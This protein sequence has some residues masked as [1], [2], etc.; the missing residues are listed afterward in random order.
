MR[1]GRWRR[2]PRCKSRHGGHL[3]AFAFAI[4]A[5]WLVISLYGILRTLRMPRSVALDKVVNDETKLES[6]AP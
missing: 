3:S 2:S 4:E 1:V 6:D 5:F